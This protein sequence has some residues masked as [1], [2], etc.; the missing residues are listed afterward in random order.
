[1]GDAERKEK[2][3]DVRRVEKWTEFPSNKGEGFK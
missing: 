1:M 2:T 3:E